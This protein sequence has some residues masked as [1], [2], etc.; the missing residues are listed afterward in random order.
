MAEKAQKN[1]NQ[2]SL[3]DW[4][5]KERKSLKTRRILSENGRPKIFTKNGRFPAKTGGLESLF[6]S[7]VGSGGYFLIW[8]VPVYTTDWNCHY[9]RYYQI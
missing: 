1:S 3:K 4:L 6:F 2:S 7:K 8:P 9:L 5:N